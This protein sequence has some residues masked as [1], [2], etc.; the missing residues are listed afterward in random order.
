MLHPA[1]LADL[2]ATLTQHGFAVGMHQTLAAARLLAQL[3]RPVAA[4]DLV[5]WLA[6][7]FCSNPQQQRDFP[8][9]YR[10]WLHAAPAFAVPL[11]A[12]SE[13]VLQA[14]DTANLAA[15]RGWSMHM[16]LRAFSLSVA[17]VALLL[18]AA[19]EVVKPPAPMSEAT[20]VAAPPARGTGAVAE[21]DTR[22]ALP[23]PPPAT[24]SGVSLLAA[25]AS[26]PLLAWL[27]VSLRRRGF[28]ERHPGK[29][30]HTAL[31]V[32]S[33][34]IRVLSSWRL[35]VASLGRSLRRKVNVP[36]AELDV[37]ATLA[38]YCRHGMV[39]RLYFG[40]R[41]EPEYLVLVN[42]A[43]KYD[44]CARIA[45]EL[46]RI[47]RDDS[48]VQ[49]HL[50][51]Y[52][53]DLRRLH[54][55][56]RQGRPA[57]RG[58][59]YLERLLGRYP[60]ARILIFSDGNELISPLNGQAVAWLP[61][62]LQQS[63]PMLITPR[64]KDRWSLREYLLH[65]AG[66]QIVALD[67]AG[68]A[69]MGTMLA[70]QVSEARMPYGG[71]QARPPV[72]LCDV[73]ALLD[74]M[75]PPASQVAQ[76]I[77]AL[78]SDLGPRGYAWL[79]ACAIY[80]EIH[81]GITLTMGHVLLGAMDPVREAQAL[82]RLLVMLSALPWLRHGYM[83]DWLRSEL[84][85]SM[86]PADAGLARQAL[87]A[88]LA[89]VTHGEQGQPGTDAL[90]IGLLPRP[91]LPGDMLA[92]ARALLR[93][94]K[95]PAIREDR[96]YL[97]FMSGKRSG[98]AVA[99]G[100]TIA[101]LFYQHG[102]MLGQPRKIPYVMASLALGACAVFLA[103]H[104]ARKAE[105]LPIPRQAPSV[106]DVPAMGKPVTLPV[107]PSEITPADV[108]FSSRLTGGRTSY[109]SEYNF[110]FWLAASAE[111]LAQVREVNYFLDE[112]TFTKK[113]YVSADPASG[114]SQSYDGWGCLNFITL[115]I[116]YKTDARKTLEVEMCAALNKTPVSAK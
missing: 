39:S 69:A 57:Q 71:M 102:A 72:Y 53:D 52:R 86:A 114:F 28:L 89:T 75:A 67:T 92:G 34:K 70:M 17:A 37:P 21:Y 100:E 63:Q 7:I 18:Y 10:Q 87:A 35:E 51:G 3:E 38:S 25:S 66:L 40:S 11:E 19:V 13:A 31:H 9:I 62:L 54:H 56:P 110:R 90:R 115:T 65:R 48:G 47:L 94:P 12:R 116:T 4:A 55:Q 43:G 60:Q 93:S 78:R 29:Q 88:Y 27:L 16:L 95:K 96:V 50:Y 32:A 64:E 5:P 112:K 85:D 103:L 23:E 26:L 91:S 74:T 8:A 97:R 22:A 61:M 113:H 41:Q 6:P 30:K 83:P 33:S 46:V 79:C 106:S 44:H 111:S 58:V 49:V 108:R 77:S 109:G 2:V 81:W 24:A 20:S 59:E 80:P 82:P 98:L 68:L 105:V 45:E 107:T 36:T 1:Q 76:I 104:A 15:S 14:S 42:R 84:L 99:A 101:Q 73:I